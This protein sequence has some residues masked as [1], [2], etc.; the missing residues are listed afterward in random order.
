MNFLSIRIPLRVRTP[1]S[2]S[3]LA[4]MVADPSREEPGDC[5]EFCARG[6]FPSLADE[7]FTE[8]DGELCLGLEPFTRR[9]F[10]FVD[11]VIE[12]QI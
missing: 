4:S 6:L 1:S 2:Q 7:P 10:P 5:R 9:S 12:H 11:R 8:D 3:V